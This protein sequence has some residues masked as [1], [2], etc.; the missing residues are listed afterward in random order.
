MTGGSENFQ[1]LD[2]ECKRWPDVI[3]LGEHGKDT[4][5]CENC[6]PDMGEDVFVQR[7]GKKRAGR[8]LDGRTWDEVPDSPANMLAG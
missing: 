2:P 7:V 4:R 1:T 3:R 5:I 8:L 6:T